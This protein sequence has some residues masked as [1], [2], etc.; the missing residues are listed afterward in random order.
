MGIG[1]LR[2]ESGMITSTF[3]RVWAMNL[4]RRSRFAGSLRWLSTLSYC[5][6]RLSFCQTP[7]YAEKP[8]STGTTIPVMNREAGETSQRSVPD[9]IHRVAKPTHRRMRKDRLTAGSEGSILIK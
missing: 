3:F 7:L 1:M 9:Q 5:L 6:A 2:V 8:P 4:S